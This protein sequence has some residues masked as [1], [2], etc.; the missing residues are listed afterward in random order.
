[1]EDTLSPDLIL[2][3][4]THCFYPCGGLHGEDPANV[5]DAKLLGSFQSQEAEASLLSW[6]R[7]L[8]SRDVK[9]HHSFQWERFFSKTKQM[10]DKYNHL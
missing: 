10:F 3:Q 2:A 7:Q 4:D 5:L 8:C 6:Q 1:M 9:N